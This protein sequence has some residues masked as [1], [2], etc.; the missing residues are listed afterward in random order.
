MRSGHGNFVMRAMGHGHFMPVRVATGI[1]SVE[2]VAIIDGLAAG[3]E[4]AVNGQF[5]L[6]AAASIADAVQR[7]QS[8]SAAKAG[9]AEGKSSGT[10][11]AP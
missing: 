8:G 9:A 6:D 3:E 5:L 4:V 2:R 1:E 11:G 7:M 10:G